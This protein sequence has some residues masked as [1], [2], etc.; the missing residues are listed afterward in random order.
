MK[1]VLIASFTNSKVLKYV[2]VAEAAVVT[3]LVY[4]NSSS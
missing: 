4:S 1:I 3:C 2:I